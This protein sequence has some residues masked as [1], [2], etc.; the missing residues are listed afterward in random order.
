M[1]GY[2][3]AIQFKAGYNGKARPIRLGYAKPD[4]KGGWFV[5]LDALPLPDEQGRVSFK[6]VPQRER[7]AGQSNAPASGGYA[8]D[9]EIPFA[10][11]WR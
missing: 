7:D 10:A 9:D 6:I 5:N 11:E 8:M 1:S 4:Q 2:F 3:D